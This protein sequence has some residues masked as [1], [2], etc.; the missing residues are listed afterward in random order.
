MVSGDGADLHIIH[1]TS[2]KFT[3]N[4]LRWQEGRREGRRNTRA[5]IGRRIHIPSPSKE[6]GLDETGPGAGSSS[7]LSQ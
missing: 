6:K 4:G 7:W 1:L 2:R 3:R 5:A